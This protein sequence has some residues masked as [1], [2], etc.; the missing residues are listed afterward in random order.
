MMQ[1]GDVQLAWTRLPLVNIEAISGR[2][3]ILILAPHPDDESLGCGG[4]IAACCAADRPPFVLVLTDGTGS[5]PRSRLY[6]AARLK[7]TRQMEA[8]RA[9]AILGLGPSRSAFL[10]LPDT[11]A[12]HDGAALERA[13]AA[14]AARA[15]AIGCTTIAAPWQ[16]DPHCDHL[17]AHRMAEAAAAQLGLRHI[18]Y[19]VWGWILPADDTL[20]VVVAGGRL[21]IE[22]HLSAKRRAIAAHESQHGALITDD[23]TGFQLPRHLLAAFDE[24]FEVFLDVR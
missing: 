20:D 4:L 11:A 1:A 16:H 5:H 2:G 3:R 13:V 15:R 24:P 17:A 21:D 8:R 6:P 12:P 7:D 23:P 18:A 10:D 9:M 14:I 19:P 22:R